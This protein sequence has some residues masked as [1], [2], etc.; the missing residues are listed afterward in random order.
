M[1][2]RC[3]GALLCVGRRFLQAASCAAVGLSRRLAIG[4]RSA[5][6]IASLV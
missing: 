5:A 6:G 2:E 3:C 1:Q 4:V